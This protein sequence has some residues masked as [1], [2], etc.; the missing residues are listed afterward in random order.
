VINGSK[1]MKPVCVASQ[2][3]SRLMWESSDRSKSRMLNVPQLD[4]FEP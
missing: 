4:N 2:K 3:R 1:P